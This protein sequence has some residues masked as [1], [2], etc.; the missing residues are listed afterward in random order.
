MW[1]MLDLSL[2]IV[3]WNVR[4]FLAACLKSIDANRGDLRLEVILVDSAST[5]D[6]VQMAQ[7]L[8]LPWIKVLPQSENVGFTCGNNIGLRA[9]QGRYLML[10]NPDT[11]IV[12]DALPAMVAYMDA[13]PEVGI[14]GPHTLNT[15][16]TTQSSR[17]RF[18][19]FLTGLFESTWWQPFAPRQILDRFYVRDIADTDTAEVDWVQ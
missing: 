14:V 15:D 9:A 8:G 2:I 5:D 3:S 1:L 13:Q 16:G 10:L 18:P 4:D 6:S 12:G 17:R 11:E 7:S 19:T